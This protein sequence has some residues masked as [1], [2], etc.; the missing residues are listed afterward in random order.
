VTGGEFRDRLEQ[1]LAFS[2]VPTPTDDAFDKLQTY[3]E[4]LARWNAKI[5]LTAL[6]LDEPTDDAIDR[7]F[8][9]PLAAARHFPTGVDGWFDLGSGGGSPA[10]PLQVATGAAGLTMVES[11]ERKA[12]FLRE[13]VRILEIRASVENMRFE[14][15][16]DGRHGGIADVVTVRAVRPDAAMF[17]AAATV[18][19]KAGRLLIFQ[20]HALSTA[21]GGFRVVGTE[22]LLVHKTSFLATYGRA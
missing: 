16:G 1:R 11:R 18:L 17:S 5:N 4:L 2:S 22:S 19:K 21:I 13:V 8:T 20:S 10:I 7:L 14:D 3:F 12:A 15:L 9:E 6:P